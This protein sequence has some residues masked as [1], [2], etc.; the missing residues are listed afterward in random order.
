MK[1]N[2]SVK[3]SYFYPI[4]YE[5]RNREIK[6]LQ[7][8]APYYTEDGLKF[9]VCKNEEKI[10][11]EEFE[12]M[13]ISSF[14]STA[15]NKASKSAEEG[16]LH[17]IEFIKDKIRQS[18]RIKPT[19]FMGYLFVKSVPL[20]FE[21]KGNR[22]E[23]SFTNSIEV[24]GIKLNEV[25]IGGER[26]Y[27]FGKARIIK[28]SQENLR[29]DAIDLFNSGTKIDTT[30]DQLTISSGD[31]QLLVLSHVTIENLDTKLIR[32]DIE[33]LIG[34]EWI[35]K[36]PGQKISQIAKICVTPGSQLIC[37]K[38]LSIGNFGIWEVV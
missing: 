5:K 16:T 8:F 9:G 12:Q 36:G 2:E 3:L 35:E 21:V 18:E 17:E 30:K 1:V 15:L 38:V 24:N 33:P 34:R 6:V 37:D 11:L 13:F 14:V 26:N 19:I 25:W 4:E 20:K 29:D 23:L 22:I 31:R 10:S 28:L 27:G 32:G 7:V